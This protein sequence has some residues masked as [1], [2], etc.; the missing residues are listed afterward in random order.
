MQRL[1]A[2]KAELAVAMTK[3]FVHEAL[4]KIESFA[5]ETLSRMHKGDNLQTQLSVLKQRAQRRPI[6]RVELK[7]EIA[8]RVSEGEGYVV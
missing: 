1:G 4:A 7:R 6:D 5:E 3:V 8:K 2:G